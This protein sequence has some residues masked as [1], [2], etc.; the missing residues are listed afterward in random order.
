MA[1]LDDLQVVCEDFLAAA[2]V[3]LDA[4]PAGSPERAFVSYEEPTHDCCPQL[5]VWGTTLGDAET[6]AGDGALAR[7]QRPR[8]IGVVPVFSIA[9]EIVRCVP[10]LRWSLGRFVLP[11]PAEIAAAA[12]VLNEDVWALRNHLTRELKSGSLSSV[13][14]GA[15]RE[16]AVPV[17]ELGGCAGW[18]LNYGL[19]VEGGVLEPT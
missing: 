18:R 3:A 8:K 17:P 5:V 15:F 13:C 14:S 16:G 6:F 7:A 10:G 12:L 19:P 4:T 2:V 11:T 9:V 1:N